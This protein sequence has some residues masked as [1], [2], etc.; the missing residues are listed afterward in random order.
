[1]GR[2]EPEKHSGIWK[3]TSKAIQAVWRKDRIE[4]FHNRLESLR[5]QISIRV[6]AA[7]N[8]KAEFQ[9]NV[10]QNGLENIGRGGREIVEIMSINQSILESRMNHIHQ[11]TQ[12]LA[13]YRHNKTIGA[14]LTLRNG[15]MRVLRPSSASEILVE[16][17]Q[18]E[19]PF[20]T[21]RG[22]T[23]RDGGTIEVENRSHDYVQTQILD[24]LYFRQIT[25]RVDDVSL[26]HRKTFERVFHDSAFE[27]K[28]WN[29]LPLW[30]EFG[31]G[32]YWVN[33]KA[34]AGK[35]TLMKFIRED[36]R[37]RVALTQWAAGQRLVLASFFFW[38]LG[39]EIQRSQDGLLRALLFD[40]V[41]A[42]LTL[43]PI[44]FPG[45]TELLYTAEVLEVPLTPN[46]ER[47]FIT[48]SG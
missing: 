36:E 41:E 45:Y 28:H 25:D 27:G 22:S 4:T 2:F 46:S 10:V 32:C 1:L 7:L 19:Q 37:T 31:S 42:S 21:L 20:V 9:L 23:S 39:S 30:L 12:Q 35:S 16:D 38:N 34:G 17:S 47:H 11:T 24:C 40:V 33:G 6:L 14:I 26:A 18:Q 5:S 3:S 13:E 43:L 29:H 48:W 8:A 15:D 44:F